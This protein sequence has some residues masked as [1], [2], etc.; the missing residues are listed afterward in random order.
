MD[1][2]DTLDQVDSAIFTGDALESERHR[3]ELK[4][5]CDRW[6]RKLEELKAAQLASNID[7]LEHQGTKQIATGHLLRCP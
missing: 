6:L 5:Y 1:F 3:S 2:E 4:W 7:P